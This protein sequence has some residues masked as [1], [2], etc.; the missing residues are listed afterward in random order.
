MLGKFASQVEMLG[1]NATFVAFLLEGLR[2][3]KTPDPQVKIQKFLSNFLLK[4]YLS[5]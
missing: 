2:S 3:S 4:N 1:K 5:L